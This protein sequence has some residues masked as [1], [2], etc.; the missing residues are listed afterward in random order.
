TPGSAGAGGAAAGE[1]GNAEP[2]AGA[3]GSDAGAG[4]SG[5]GE[6][7]AA[8]AA[9]DL[10]CDDSDPCT[11]DRCVLTEDGPECERT[12]LEGLVPDGLDE[13]IAGG[14]I[15]QVTVAAGPDAFYLSAF[16]AR[17]DNGPVQ[18]L[19]RGCI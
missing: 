4:G 13:T 18:T 17:A 12:P 2:G 3:G 8:G 7:G 9:C 19:L 14:R 11:L 15:P 6:A 1:G 10:D 5:A 16:D